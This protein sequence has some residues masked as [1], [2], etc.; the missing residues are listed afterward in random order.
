MGNFFSVSS[1]NDVEVEGKNQK[2]VAPT[3][4]VVS[5]GMLK[6]KRT[7]RKQIRNGRNRTRVISR[8]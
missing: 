4:P 1:W 5:G 8:K 3:V 7:T 6:G 2:N